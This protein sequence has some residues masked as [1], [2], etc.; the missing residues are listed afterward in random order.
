MLIPDDLRRSSFDEAHRR[1]LSFGAFVREAL[2]A[3]LSQAHE[4]G[5]IGD[6]FLD[7]TGVYA[8]PVPTDSSTRVDDALYGERE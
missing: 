8:G 2:R 3:A 4:A 5:R 6:S 1:G 7:D